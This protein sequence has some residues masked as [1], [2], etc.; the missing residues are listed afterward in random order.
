[1]TA[2]R[3][4]PGAEEGQHSPLRQAILT[5]LAIRPM[6]GY[7]VRRTYE[8]SMQRVWYAPIGQVYPTLRAMQRDGLLESSV[9]I[10]QDRPNR[11]VYRLTRSGERAL[12]AWLTGPAALPR[13]HHEFLHKMFLL[14]RMPPADRTAFVE[15]YVESCTVWADRL[16][17]ID[18]KFSTAEHGVF[19]ESAHYQL[20]SLRHLRRV[21]ATEIESASEILAGLRNDA[22]GSGGRRRRAGRSA[23]LAITDLDLQSGS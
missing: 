20:L 1:M 23:D 11:K 17:A 10:Q 3:A 15:S 6:S 2:K 5:L 12:D 22:P 7:D 13:M 9:H 4:T 21:V 16:A 14:D 8:R 18:A 19:A